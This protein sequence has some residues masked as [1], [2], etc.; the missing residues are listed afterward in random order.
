M[1]DEKSVLDILNAALVEYNGPG[2]QHAQD[3]LNIFLD[4]DY[5]TGI[6]IIKNE[7]VLRKKSHKRT[8]L[9]NH[10]REYRQNFISCESKRK[11]GEELELALRRYE[12]SNWRFDKR[13]SECRYQRNDKNWLNWHIL[14]LT[15][16]GYSAE[17]IRKDYL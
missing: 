7:A 15:P 8:A 4:G 12:A 11:A 6:R 17:T 2:K 1:I 16:D 5:E 13:D 3:T 10:M 14:K 9:E